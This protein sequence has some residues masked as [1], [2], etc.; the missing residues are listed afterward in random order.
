MLREFEPELLLI[1]AGFDA[2]L[3]DIQGKMRMSAQGYASLTRLLL[4]LPRCAPVAIFE[5]GY[6][7]DVSA[8]CVEAVLRVMLEEAEEAEPQG[9]PA[10]TT[11]SAAAGA[12]GARTART[13]RTAH[14]SGDS[15]GSL[16][17][18]TELLLRQVI[19]VHREFWQCFQEPA[20]ALAVDEFFR[21]PTARKRGRS[22]S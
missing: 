19:G 4:T 15:T 20:H 10:A 2:A 13:A 9:A 12:S 14:S 21:Q 11:T 6:H 1:S 22:C 17:E 7:L 16:G 8:E 5:G 18:H 3:G